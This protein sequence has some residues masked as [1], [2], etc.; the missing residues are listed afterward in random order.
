MTVKAIESPLSI[1][2]RLKDM[3]TLLILKSI[4]GQHDEDANVLGALDHAIRLIQERHDKRK[5]ETGDNFHKEFARDVMRAVE[6]GDAVITD[7]GVDR[8]VE[9]IRVDSLTGRS[10][11]IAGREQMTY[12]IK[13]VGVVNR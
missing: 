7:V 5:A 13:A 1:Q 6:R 3:Q 2:E 9:S 11:Q 8:E 12:T 4:R 10:T